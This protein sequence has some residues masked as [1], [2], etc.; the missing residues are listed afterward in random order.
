MTAD[1]PAAT[2]ADQVWGGISGLPGYT[3]KGVGVAVLDS[4]C[5]NHASIRRSV[6]ASFD[7][8]NSKNGLD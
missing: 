8:T 6:V 5:S 3:G 1:T 7:F 4:G 2:G